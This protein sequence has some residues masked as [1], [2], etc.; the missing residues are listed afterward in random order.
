MACRSSF[1]VLQRL[2]LIGLS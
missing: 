2:W 1:P